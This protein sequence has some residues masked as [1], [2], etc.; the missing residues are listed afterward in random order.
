MNS[1]RPHLAVLFAILVLAVSAFAI[2][3]SVASSEQFWLD[4][5]HTSWVVQGD[6]SGLSSR[7]ADGNQQPIFFMLVAG[8][9]ALLGHSEFSLRAVSVLA[10]VG[11]MVASAWLTWRWTRSSIAGILVAILVTFDVQFVFYGTEARPY[12]LVE[13][14]SVIQ[15]MFFVHAVFQSRLSNADANARS[16]ARS[17]RSRFSPLVGWAVV[18]VALVYTHVTAVWLLAVEVVFLT[19]LW[20]LRTRRNS[21]EAEGRTAELSWV[22]FVVTAMVVAV[23]LI[24]AVFQVAWIMNRKGNWQSVSSV[25]GLWGESWRVILL[26]IGLP[27]V[28]LVVSRDIRRT[29]RPGSLFDRTIYARCLDS[30]SLLAFVALWALGPFVIVSVLAGTG[31]APLALTRYTL[32]G[33]LGLP[34][35]AGFCVG[36]LPSKLNQAG[37]ALMVLGLFAIQN[38]VIQLGLQ[39]RQIPQFRIEDWRTPVSEINSNPGKSGQPVF[40]FGNVIEDSAALDSDDPAFQEYL[41]FPLLG[42]KE[43]DAADRI[44]Q[45]GST[46]GWTHFSN[47]QIVH[48]NQQGGAWVV[49]RASDE[50]VNEIGNELRERLALLQ[51]VPPEVI[52]ISKL[53]TGLSPVGLLLVDW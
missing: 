12:A 33:A 9:V 32:V 47:E 18:S 35:F 2:R 30:K 38:P 37:L 19:G 15:V 10:G 6:W 26:L 7:A 31:I 23:A 13:F 8:M 51:G 16:V 40:L 1:S 21:R 28:Y 3:Y 20:L 24:P 27:L 49:I 14:L 22:R 52:R 36:S 53:E 34:V 29:H 25:M 5:L 17:A 45:S 41:L 43:F 42:L 44:V 11:M 4:E 46:L 39:A 50:L 48:A